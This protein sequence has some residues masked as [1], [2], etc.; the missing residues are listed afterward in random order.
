MK[1]RRRQPTQATEP[2]N[3]S[4][5]W[6]DRLPIGVC[7]VRSNLQ[8]VFWNS[9]LA[10]WTQI[11][12][13]QAVSQSID[14][15]LPQLHLPQNWQQAPQ[16]QALE[17]STDLPAGRM[18]VSIALSQ[19]HYYT[20]SLQR[21]SDRDCYQDRFQSLVSN[22][23][24]AVFRCAIDEHWTV[25]YISEAIE[26]ICGYP[27]SDFIHNRVRTFASHD[28]PDDVARVRRVVTEAVSQNR[29]YAVEYRIF[30]ADGSI[31]WVFDRGRGVLAPDGKIH[32]EGVLLD[33]TDRKLAEAQFE[34]Q[35]QRALLLQQI[36]E[37]IHRSLDAEQIFHTTATQIRRA[38]HVD[39]CL[40]YTYDT[41]SAL[42]LLPVAEYQHAYATRLAAEIPIAQFDLERLLTQDQAIVVRSIENFA[43]SMLAVRTSYQGEPNG[44]I[45]LHQCRQSGC[46]EWTADDRDL[47]QAVA[48]Q[49]GIALAQARLLE[50]ETQQR[51]ELTCK[52]AA[53][54][55]ARKRAELEN[56]A[57]SHFLATMSHEIRT[58]MN[59]V[60]GLADLLRDTP[61]NDQQRD[62]IETIRTSG[63]SLL[64]IVNDILDFSKIEAGKLELEQQPFNLRSCIE[65][66]IDLLAPKALEKNLDLAYLI[67]ADVPEVI[68]GDENRLRQILVNLLSN[69]VKFTAA[70][71]VTVTVSARCL[72]A[73]VDSIY[74]LRFMVQ[75]T[76]VGIPSD[77]LNRLF[78][79]FSQVDSSISRTYGGSGLGLVISQRLI[80]MMGGRIWVDSEVGRGSTFYC[81][82]MAQ[83]KP[84]PPVSDARLAD[85]RL[86]VVDANAV[87]REDLIVQARS[88]GMK[89]ASASDVDSAIALLKRSS[90]DVV[91]ID[92]RFADAIDLF[93]Q[94]ALPLL[95]TPIN[96]ASTLCAMTLSKPVKRSQLHAA[97][98][99]MLHQT[100][101]P[102]IA[103]DAQN[104]IASLRSSAPSSSDSIAQSL[105]VL[106]AE[107]NVVNQKVII[108]LLKRLGYQADLVKNGH[109]VL[110]ALHDASQPY[111]VVLMDV[112]MP[113]MDGITATQE[114][115]K[116]WLQ[117]RP[118]IIAV[119]AS[120][121]QGDYRDCL[122]AGMDDYLSKPID[123]D[124]L[125]QALSCCPARSPAEPLPAA[126]DPLAV[127]V[128]DEL[129]GKAV[130][131]ELIDSYRQESPHLLQK[132][133]TA[134][135]QQDA[136]ALRLAAHTLKASSATLGAI[137]LSQLCKSIELQAVQN[138]VA[139]AEQL[140]RVKLEYEQAIAV[141]MQPF[142]TQ[143]IVSQVG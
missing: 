80:E 26:A 88:W 86:L 28:H 136:S 51:Q 43:E 62:F 76:G 98:I 79:P 129:L 122:E 29:P 16:T 113:E 125:K 109:E 31:R 81:S 133:Q 17:F 91:L 130:L 57:K 116:R 3:H 6:L 71:E 111:D 34:Q 138:Q 118:R 32:V 77:R 92:S 68:I 112:Q 128:L 4:F 8:V 9:T 47:L 131:V 132:M 140:Q 108:H 70:G 41:T 137:A 2:Q 20:F 66:A 85:K 21:L 53:L 37:E 59:A 74:A 60:I 14:T 44:V 99:G 56:Q 36:T 110:A 22:L 35:F 73:K 5:H 102:A 55:Q 141:L 115:C 54:E 124:S 119:T 33:V 75:D 139:S 126:I 78:R 19:P 100:D 25:E 12:P 120:A 38:F 64:A 63:A 95:L 11:S 49:M 135:A 82:M 87:R 84:S 105:R 61:L 1:K 45:C 39:R 83:V 89:V 101:S 58:P 10:T 121:T 46:R 117:N 96:Q 50:Q 106:V 18:Q 90:F 67:E 23:P 97:L 93:R 69:A 103:P 48:A 114:I 7:V 127:Q 42:H 40:I 27:A 134:I 52:N 94:L 72:R 24:G 143:A 65:D 15:L 13:Q 142:M 104:G 107:D 30:H 123:I